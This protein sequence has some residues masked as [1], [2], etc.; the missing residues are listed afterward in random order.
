M[1]NAALTR[2]LAIFSPL[3]Q[4]RGIERF[5]IALATAV[6][7]VLLRGLIDPALGHVALSD[8]VKSGH[9]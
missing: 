6:L 7:A 2:V 8:H 1:T 3:P 9:T 4:Q 5:T